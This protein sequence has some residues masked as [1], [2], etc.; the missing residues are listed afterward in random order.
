M[1]KIFIYGGTCELRFL[2]AK[3]ICY[4]LSKND[5]E[6][7]YKPKDADII[8]F[9]TCATLDDLVE[10]S[11][12]KIKEFKKY[13]AELIVAGCLPSIEKEGLSKF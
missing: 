13:D 5:Y 3:K 2:D 8:I 1:K 6:I 11:F 4:Y 12:N 10:Y 7:V 9:I